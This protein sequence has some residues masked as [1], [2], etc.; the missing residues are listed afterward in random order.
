M[1]R[2]GIRRAPRPK[3][4]LAAWWEKVPSG[5]R[6]L[7]VSGCSRAREALMISRNTVRRLS[8]GKVPS[9]TPATRSRT[10]RSRSGT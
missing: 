2:A 3:W 1:V 10:A 8:S 7:T 6:K 9:L 4:A 5:P